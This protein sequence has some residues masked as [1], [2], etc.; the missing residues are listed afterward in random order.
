M[1]QEKK[2]YYVYCWIDDKNG[3]KPFYV[4]KGR[5]LRAEAHA[6][7]SSDEKKESVVQSRIKELENNGGKPY[8]RRF[9][10][11]LSN[12]C[13]HAVE[14]AL[15]NT[16]DDLC[17]V[18]D[19]RAL[20]NIRRKKDFSS[21]DTEYPGVDFFPFSE[22]LERLDAAD[23]NS[24]YFKSKVDAYQKAGSKH[25]AAIGSYHV[26]TSKHTDIKLWM[27]DVSHKKWS[28]T[29]DEKTGEITIEMERVSE[30][31]GSFEEI[32]RVHD[33]KFTLNKSAAKKGLPTKNHFLCF[34]KGLLPN[35]YIQF[36]GVYKDNWEESRKRDTFVRQRIST[37][38][39][40][41]KE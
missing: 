32:Q 9:M 8:V 21:W 25:K 1:A 10:W 4:G 7:L 28:N 24:R 37:K 26:H 34:M 16:F 30:R 15:I 12:D 33:Q 2:D 35:D 22:K 38:W 3:H 31:H 39:E 20:H 17:N 13:A 27:G 14:T 41:P 18:S 6:T 29:Y 40:I 11:G 36:V 5:G 19:G 23:T